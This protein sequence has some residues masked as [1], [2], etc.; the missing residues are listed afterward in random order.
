MNKRFYLLIVLI[1]LFTGC[2]DKIVKMNDYSEI[3]YSYHPHANSKLEE[4]AYESVLDDKSISNKKIRLAKK[5]DENLNSEL[6][7]IISNKSNS[8]IM[9][10]EQRI[11]KNTCQI[12]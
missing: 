12:V 6:D 11:Q 8:N 2:G 9:S 10:G 1:F 4:V 3:N 5:L 7:E